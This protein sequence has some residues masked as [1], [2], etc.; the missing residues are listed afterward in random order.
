MVCPFD[1]QVLPLREVG[2]DMPNN[3][4]GSLLD[5]GLGGAWASRPHF[6][7][8]EEVVKLKVIDRTGGQIR[9]VEIELTD[10]EL[11]V[12]GIAPSYYVKQLALHA[13]LDVLHSACELAVALRLEVD[14]VPRRSTDTGD[15]GKND[16]KEPQIVAGEEWP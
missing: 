1:N 5:V 15:C 7:E 2:M 8:L 16:V 13:A 4:P 14:V 12:R 11:V 6:D 3:E 9:A 10:A